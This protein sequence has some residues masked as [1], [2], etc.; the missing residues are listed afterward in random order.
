MS[1]R[2]AIALGSNIDDPE[3]HVARAFDEIAALPGTR[4]VARS[5]L[6][7]TQPV[8]YANQPDFVNAMALVDTALEPRALLE[9]LLAIEKSHGRVRTIPNGP[10]TLDLDII[11][12][13]DR[14]ID[15]PGLKVPHP[16][17]KD[18][19]FVMG[20]LREVWPDAVI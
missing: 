9:A 20:P 7:R 2:A 18:R 4:V 3:R 8:G 19:P 16:R 10:R 5:R 1:V 12:Y 13:G 14:V 6:H 11:V 17:A 15:E